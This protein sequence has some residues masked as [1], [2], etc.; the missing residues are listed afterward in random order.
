MFLVKSH[1]YVPLLFK[2]MSLQIFSAI[3]AMIIHPATEKHIAKFTEH[4]RYVVEETEELYNNVT[5]PH[6]LQQQFSIQVRFLI[7]EI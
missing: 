1:V 7:E 5:L 6:L 2:V 3:K 4:E